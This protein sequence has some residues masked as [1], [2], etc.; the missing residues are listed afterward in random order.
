LALAA[1]HQAEQ[2]QAGDAG[3]EGFRFRDFAGC[4][5]V[6]RDD[7]RNEVVIAADRIQESDAARRDCP[8]RDRTR[9]VARKR[10]VLHAADRLKQDAGREI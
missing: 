1:A 2:C 6:G 10:Q 7:A 5:H 8:G 3:R 9:Q 4:G